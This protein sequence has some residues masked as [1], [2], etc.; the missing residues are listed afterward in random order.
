MRRWLWALALCG[1]LTWGSAEAQPL[2]GG[3]LGRGS[4]G[5][6]LPALTGNAGKALL[7]NVT[8]TS[9]EWTALAGTGTVTSVGITA[10]NIFAVTGSPIT[11]AGTLALALADQNANL[12]WAGPASGAAAAPT[13]RSLVALDLGNFTLSPSLRLLTLQDATG[14]TTPLTV[15]ALSL[16]HIS[17]PTRPY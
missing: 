6:S 2:T 8:E 12:V 5:S 14:D 15:R 11:A 9:T 16:I 17:E 1:W 13:F 3:L 10:P 7:V 4:S